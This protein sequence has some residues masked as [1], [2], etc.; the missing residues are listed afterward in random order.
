MGTILNRGAPSR[1]R[2]MNFQRW[3]DARKLAGLAGG[4]QVLAEGPRRRALVEHALDDRLVG[5]AEDVV[6]VLARVLRVA[7]RM[8]AAEHGDDAALAEQVADG[9]GELRGLRER[10]DEHDVDVLRQ[11][12]RQVL[13]PRV[14]DELDVVAQ[15]LGPDGQHLRHDAGEVRVHDAGVEG[16]G[17]APGNDVD[18]SDPQ[19]LHERTLGPDRRGPNRSSRRASEVRRS[20]FSIVPRTRGSGSRHS[21]SLIRPPGRA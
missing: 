6:E 12:G 4:A 21:G 15:L 19:L 7:A 5:E 16:P 8:R 18:D 10:A 3:R 2:A 17:L 1:I 11:D 20:I 14:A 9:V 13:E